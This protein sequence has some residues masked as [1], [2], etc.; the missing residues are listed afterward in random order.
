M[1]ADRTKK[2]VTD[3]EEVELLVCKV[4]YVFTIEKVKKCSVV[5]TVM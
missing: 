1:Y 4:A 3:F 5:D 2:A